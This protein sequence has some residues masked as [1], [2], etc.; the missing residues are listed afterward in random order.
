MGKFWNWFDHF[1]GT[2]GSTNPCFLIV[3][4]VLSFENPFDFQYG[5]KPKGVYTELKVYYELTVVTLGPI[6]NGGWDP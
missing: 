6:N 4:N 5:T 2:M 3:F 1:V